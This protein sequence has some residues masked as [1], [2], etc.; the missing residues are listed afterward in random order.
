[1]DLPFRAPLL[2]GTLA[3][4][5]AACSSAGGLPLPT[6]TDPTPSAPSSPVPSA[7]AS[8]DP[9]GSPGTCGPVSSQQEAVEC[10][11]SLDP[12]FEGIGPEDPNLIGQ[13]AFYRAGLS[14]A[15]YRVVIQVGWGDCP[16]GC[17][18]KHIWTYDVAKDGA[19]TLVSEEGSPVPAGGGE[20][21]G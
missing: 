11:L 7:P 14:D 21:P 16:S 19:I 12:L 5:L 18:E 9:G 1:M 3:F 2:V 15:G 10:V 4:V 20:L 8:P 17:I 13:S 6:P